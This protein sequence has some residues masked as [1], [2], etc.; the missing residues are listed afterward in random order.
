MLCDIAF[1]ESFSLC[2]YLIIHQQIMN[3]LILNEIYRRSINLSII[4]LI[5]VSQRVGNAEMQ[6]LCSQ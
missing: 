3:E 1:I 6:S 4:I 2:K 5:I